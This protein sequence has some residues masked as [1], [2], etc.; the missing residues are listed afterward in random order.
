MDVNEYREDGIYYEGEIEKK[1][2]NKVKEFDL[3]TMVS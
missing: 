2:Y 3:E 1:Y